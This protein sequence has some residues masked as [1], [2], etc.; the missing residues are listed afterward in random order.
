MS[1]HLFGSKGLP[2]TTYGVVY[3]TLFYE[4][5]LTRNGML[6]LKDCWIE[7]ARKFSF[8]VQL[9]FPRSLKNILTLSSDSKCLDI[10]LSV[11]Y[12]C[13]CFEI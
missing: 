8:A 13:T 10:I 9:N 11:N 5:Q 1:H 7:R 2:I 4:K 6:I 3:C 12:V